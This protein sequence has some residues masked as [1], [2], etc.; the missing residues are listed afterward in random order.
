M[1]NVLLQLGVGWMY[2]EAVTRDKTCSRDITNMLVALGQLDEE[3][4]LL[5]VDYS[6]FR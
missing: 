3:G 1:S 5:F 2:Q 4:I 6:N